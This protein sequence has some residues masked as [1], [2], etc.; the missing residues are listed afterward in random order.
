MDGYKLRT[1]KKK[2]QIRKVAMDLFLTF[3]FEKVTLAEI[4]KKAHVSPVTIY[5]HFGTKDELVRDVVHTF[6]E[7]EWESRLQTIKREDLSFPEKVEKLIIDTTEISGVNPSFLNKMI[8]N[9]PELALFIQDF[10]QDR[11]KYIIEFFEEG[12][13]LGYVDPD[14]TTDS[15]IMYLNILQNAAKDLQFFNDSQKNSKLGKD[16]SKLFFYG[17]LIRK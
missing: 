9:D 12:K 2:E 10:F 5:N 14:I 8:D 15:I 11:M 7:R 16:L 4:A 17:L 1:E 6:L 3:G 13:Q